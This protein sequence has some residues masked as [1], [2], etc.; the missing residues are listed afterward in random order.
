MLALN[1][2]LA[3]NQHSVHYFPA[4]LL[5]LILFLLRVLGQLL[6]AFF[7]VPFLPPM[8]EWFS[9][10]MAYRELFAC[11]ILIIIVFG[12][13]CIEFA[14]GRGIFVQPNRALGNFLL[15]FGSV[16]LFVMV[17]RY[18]VR[19]SLYPLERWT[20]GSIPIFFHWVLAT[21]LIVLGTFHWRHSKRFLRSARAS[22]KKRAALWSL[23][24]ITALGIIAWA[25]WQILP[26][27][28]AQQYSLGSPLYAVRVERGVAFVTSDSI[29]LVADIYEPQRKLKSPT[30]LVR[31]PLTNSIKNQFYVGLLARIC[32]EHG[33]TVVVQDTSARFC[34]GASS[35][36]PRHDR[37]D[38][39]ETLKW[40][41]KYRMASNEKSN[42]CTS[43][44]GPFGLFYSRI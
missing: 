38:G 11:Q 26:A 2:R 33:Y 21:F 34:S 22:F 32:A 20:G 25:T 6:V 44:A 8:E 29:K 23:R 37:E 1:S 31:I 3:A 18:A 36:P 14:R 9:G 28:L 19:M 13:V 42:K 5:L 4:L 12:R 43:I 39:I 17:F 30:V 40:L 10:A 35:H 27:M 24:F 41:L 16:Y 15:Q 7:S